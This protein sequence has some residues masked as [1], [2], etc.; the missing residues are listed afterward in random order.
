MAAEEIWSDPE[1]V[2]EFARREP[3]V[4]LQRI[5]SDCTDPPALRVLD[6]GCAGGRNM[7]YLVEGGFDAWALDLSEAMVERIVTP[8]ARV[9]RTVPAIFERPTRRR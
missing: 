6:V 7:R 3:D 8:A 2:E 9:P 4:R 5:L 1:R